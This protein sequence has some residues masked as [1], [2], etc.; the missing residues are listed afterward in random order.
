MLPDPKKKK[1]APT[2]HELSSII[3][4]HERYLA[5]TGGVR[6]QLAHT[7]LDGLN[8]ASRTLTEI[9]LSGASLVGASL[10][11]SNLDRASFY[12]ADLRDADL[13]YTKLNRADMRGASFKGATLNFAVLDQADMRFGRMMYVGTDKSPIGRDEPGPIQPYGSTNPNGVDFSNCSMK[14]VSFGNAKLEGANFTGALLQGATFKNAQLTNA[15]FSGAVLTNV[16]L[17]DLNVPPESLVGCVRDITPETS[18]KFEELKIRLEH[19]QQWLITGGSE[20]RPAVMDGEDMR[21]LAQLLVGR[22]MTGLSARNVVGIELNFAGSELQ[23]AKFECADLRGANFSKADLRGASFR[24][25]KL[26][27]AIF[28][29]ANMA[30]L[31]LRGGTM[32]AVDLTG[33]EVSKE[34]LDKAAPV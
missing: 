21:P 14:G 6:A 2:Q 17:A 34:Q 7:I 15:N 8:L 30:A 31:P 20:G 22:R 3:L 19:H 16:N 4:Q 23:A 33:A 13:R 28:E 24:G 5:Y 18:A 26:L 27:H 32:L 25:A 29:G 12:C 1:P 9:D 11:A 10:Y